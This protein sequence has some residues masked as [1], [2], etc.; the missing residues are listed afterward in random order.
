[1]KKLYLLIA[2]SVVG[3][4][5]LCAQFTMLQKY[6]EPTSV[7]ELNKADMVRYD[8]ITTLQHGTGT[9]A[10]W[11]YTPMIIS[12]DVMTVSYMNSSS[13]PHA[14][15]FPSATLAG[16]RNSTHYA[17]YK[18]DTVAKTFELLGEFSGDATTYS[19]PKMLFKW[20]ITNGNGW[21]DTYAH[22]NLTSTVSGNYSVS[23]TGVGQL[24]LVGGK[25]FQNVMQITAQDVMTR[26]TANDTIEV[27]ITNYTYYHSLNRYPLLS[28]TYTRTAVTDSTNDVAASIYVNYLEAVGV[29]ENDI[30]ASFIIYPNPANGQFTLRVHNPTMTPV[31]ISLHALTGQL[32]KKV[33]TTGGSQIETKINAADLPRGIYI[34]R[35]ETDAFDVVR[36]IVIE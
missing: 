30:A 17:Y 19:D 36:K 33:V 20:P 26:T 32:V 16:V 28:V 14:S 31:T 35:A 2:A 13:A 1:M 5:P 22:S 27:H 4:L 25:S 6:H 11:N 34:V 3:T 7:T 21:T 15:L 18:S 8:S 23:A 9:S 12:N 29:D 24:M 10:T